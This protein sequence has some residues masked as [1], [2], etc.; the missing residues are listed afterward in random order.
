M[1]NSKPQRFAQNLNF[2]HKISNFSTKPQLF[3]QNLNF[4][5]NTSTFCTKPRF[6][7][8]NFNILHKTS[9]FCTKPQIF[10]QNLNFLHKLSNFCTKPRFF[11]QNFK[12]F[13]QNFKFFAQNFIRHWLVS[14]FCDNLLGGFN[15]SHTETRAKQFGECSGR[16]DVRRIAHRK[17]IRRW[18]GSIVQHV[19]N[20]VAMNQQILPGA[21]FVNFSSRV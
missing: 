8:Q 19:V 10:P 3:A 1:H 17:K 6:F 9:T 12:F 4:L 16:Y 18:R 15:P 7:A 2:F 5:H 20:V 13:A 11:A 14:Q 21:K